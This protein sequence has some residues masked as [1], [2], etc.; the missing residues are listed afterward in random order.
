M[1]YVSLL[2]EQNNTPLQIRNGEKVDN[3]KGG[4]YM[5]PEILKQFQEIVGEENANLIEIMGEN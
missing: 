5:T 2:G 4:I 3:I 1:L